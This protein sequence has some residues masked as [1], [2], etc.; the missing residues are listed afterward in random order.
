MFGQNGIPGE[1]E[2]MDGEVETESVLSFKNFMRRG[3]V[4]RN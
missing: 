1:K 2:E 4:W 3:S